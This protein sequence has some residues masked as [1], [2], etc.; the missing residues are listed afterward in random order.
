VQ[1]AADIG[2][3]LLPPMT[4]TQTIN[5]SS[6]MQTFQPRGKVFNQEAHTCVENRQ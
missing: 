5:F 1:A 4:R 2:Y 3:Y 6:T